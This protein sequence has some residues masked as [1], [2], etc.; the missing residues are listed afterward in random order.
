MTDGFQE[1]QGLGRSRLEPD[2]I[3]Q[4]HRGI[5][6][7]SEFVTYGLFTDHNAFEQ[8]LNSAHVSTWL[9]GSSAWL[10]ARWWSATTH[11]TTPPDFARTR[12]CPGGSPLGG[13]TG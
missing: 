7:A 1:L 12:A 3:Y 10:A 9:A 11:C 5:E 8:H 6:D 2:L 4:L 13:P